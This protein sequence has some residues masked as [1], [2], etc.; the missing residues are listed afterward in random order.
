MSKASPIKTSFNGGIQSPLLQGH[1]DAPSRQNSVKDSTNL[2]PLKQG[3]VTRRG[4]TKHANRQRNT[5]P[6]GTR[7]HLIP[8]YYND[9]DSYILDR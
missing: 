7:T 5:I 1:I 4:G 3:P 6:S 2:I 8:F 9:T